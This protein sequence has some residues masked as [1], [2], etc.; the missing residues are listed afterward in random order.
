GGSCPAQGRGA[1]P[2]RTRSS[3]PYGV[4]LLDT[5]GARGEPGTL[6]AYAPSS[7]TPDPTRRP[8]RIASDDRPNP[9]AGCT[10]DGAPDTGGAPPPRPLLALADGE[11]QD[12]V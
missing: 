7:R 2:R 1:P 11:C 10:D 8:G 12:L 4:V 3:W 6:P 5:R 9:R